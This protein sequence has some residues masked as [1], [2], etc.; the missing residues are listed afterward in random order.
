MQAK[1][2]TNRQQWNDF[3]A[4]SDLCNITQ[5][6]EWGELMS[7]KH[8]EF[9]PVGVVQEDGSLCAAML[10][11]ISTVP[12]L[13]VPYFYAPRGPIVDNPSSPAMTVLLNFVKAE[14]RKRGICMLK[15]EP[16]VVD[17]DPLWTNALH[18]YGFRT[19]PYAHH[20]RHEWV[21][22]IRGDEQELLAK[23]HKKTRQYIRTAGR[24][25]V[26]IRPGQGQSDIDAFYDLYCQTSERSEF[27]ILS[28][29]YYENFLRLYKDNAELLIAEREGRVIAAAIVARLGVWSWNM[30][31]A[32]SEESRELRINYLL[33]WKRIQW[34]REHGCWYFNSRG[35]PDV[36]EEGQEL[37]GV[38]NFKRGF[39]GFAMRSLVTHDLVY[40]PVIYQ[41]YR[42]MLDGKHWYEERQAAKKAAAERAKAEKIR[43]ER[44]KEQQAQ[45]AVKEAGQPIT[46]AASETEERR[47]AAMK[48]A[49][50]SQTRQKAQP[51]AKAKKP[52]PMPQ[53]P[54]TPRPEVM[55]EPLT[56]QPVQN[57]TLIP[58]TPRPQTERGERRKQKPQRKPQPVEVQQSEE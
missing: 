51:A 43:L 28:K 44:E 11:L 14:A 10:I 42:A 45:K 30:Y 55:P 50:P 53:I 56:P 35:I 3:V 36:L 47:K 40:R 34:A 19:I 23:M 20:L 52:Q 15:I 41:A 8:S 39:S 33:Q 46:P 5:T 2:I 12:M 57:E 48:A 7:Q 16:G 1:I 6:F 38:Y 9:L 25:D 58:E 37:Y 31:E 24:T 21:T 32:A 27:M 54:E 29:S 18:R 22:D 4:A 17:N 49:A 26:V 13:H